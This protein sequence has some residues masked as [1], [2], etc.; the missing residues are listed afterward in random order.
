MENVVKLATRIGVLAV[1][2]GVI[3]ELCL[4]DG[5]FYP[6]LVTSRAS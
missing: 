3:S 5:M 6:L 2:A 1:S 4:Y